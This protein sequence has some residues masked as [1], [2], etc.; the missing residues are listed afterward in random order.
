M[1]PPSPSPHNNTATARRA[2]LA[3]TGTKTRAFSVAESATPTP[4]GFAPQ[5][6]IEI[7]IDDTKSNTR[8][9]LTRPVW[10]SAL[11]PPPAPSPSPSPNTRHNPHNQF[12]RPRPAAGSQDAWRA[13]RLIV[14]AGTDHA[15]LLAVLGEQMTGGCLDPHN[16]AI[17]VGRLAQASQ[18]H[19]AVAVAAIAG[20][21]RFARLVR[22]LCDETAGLLAAMPPQQLAGVVEVRC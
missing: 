20:D 13:R 1:F 10:L 19:G 9:S 11:H 6:L 8:D 21:E 15:R 2:L 7:G 16:A 22:A 12:K 14:E 4:P 3:S 5:V 17:A 18:A